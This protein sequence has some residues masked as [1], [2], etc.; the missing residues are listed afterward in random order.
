[1]PPLDV[2]TCHSSEPPIPIHQ[3]KIIPAVDDECTLLDDDVLHEIQ[4]RYKI[5]APSF[6]SARA[7]P[8]HPDRHQVLE[9][10]CRAFEFRS[11]PMTSLEDR[12]FRYINEHTGIPYQLK[13]QVKEPWHKVFLLAQLELSQIPWP[14]KISAEGRKQLY[15]EKG[16]LYSLLDRMLRCTIDLMGYRNDG[17]GVNVGLDVLRSIKSLVWEGGGMELRQIKGIGQVMANKLA[18]AGVT[19]V[20]QLADLECYHIERLLSRNP[21]FGQTLIRRLAGFPRLSLSST[22]VRSGSKPRMG[23]TERVVKFDISYENTELPLWNERAPWTTLVVE[24]QDGRLV[25]FWRGN[26]KM[27]KDGKS[28]VVKIQALEGEVLTVTF[29]CEEIVGTLVRQSMTVQQA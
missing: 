12:F 22:I 27:L 24:G 28:M 6:K 14:S 26:V 1:M 2:M 21:P 3:D 4:L 29:A 25:W 10:V 23:D 17:R 7:I 8:Q 9:A 5:S 18:N 11:F 15:Q 13:E 16:K 20:H 19:T